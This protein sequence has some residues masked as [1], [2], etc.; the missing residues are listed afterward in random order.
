MIHG[1]PN[2]LS[3]TSCDPAHG[4][5]KMKPPLSDPP[6][7]GGE[8]AVTAHLHSP[9]ASSRAHIEVAAQVVTEQPR[10]PTWVN[11]SG[12]YAMDGMTASKQML[13]RSAGSMS[14]LFPGDAFGE[15]PA[16]DSLKQDVLSA[17]AFEKDTAQAL[18]N[19]PN[20]MRRRMKEK[21]LRFK[22][23]FDEWGDG[24]GLCVLTVL[25]GLNMSYV[26]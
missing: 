15:R 3:S 24:V 11:A 8:I 12:G 25:L 19:V 1:S 22:I 9:V 5:R 16:S 21:I 26:V 17:L 7:E 23:W 2:S 20:T 6:R 14:R 4:S 13:K 10:S 18:R